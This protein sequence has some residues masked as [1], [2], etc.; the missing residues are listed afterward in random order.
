MAR[1]WNR[2]RRAQV[3]QNTH[4]VSKLD[5]S[6]APW[7]LGSTARLV[8]RWYSYTMGSKLSDVNPFL[9]NPTIRK[10]SVFNSVASSS[11]IEGIRAPFKQMEAQSSV[12]TADS[13]KRLSQK[14][15]RLR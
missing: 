15:P 7:V 2:C 8:V 4:A 6:V 11:A 12:A 14:R 1:E 10:R 5:A 13:A 9:R 3:T